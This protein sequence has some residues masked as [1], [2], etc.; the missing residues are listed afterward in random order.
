MTTPIEERGET[1]LGLPYRKGRQWSEIVTID[2]ETAR[3]LFDA[4]PDQRPTRKVNIR[5]LVRAI[6]NG[7]WVVTHQGI[8][9]NVN[10]HVIDGQHRLQAI[11]E[12]GIAV[13]V[14]VTFNLP[15]GAFKA[16]DR[17]AVR[18]FGDDFIN[19]GMTQES[20]ESNTFA[21]A[22]RVLWCYE[23]FGDPTVS[24]IRSIPNTDDLLD[25][26]ERHPMLIETCRWCLT[27][28]SSL[29]FPLGPMAALLTLF[30]EVNN[31]LAINFAAQFITGEGLQRN[32]PALVL[33]E[34][35]L[36]SNARNK[37]GRNNFMFRF[38]RAWNAVCEGRQ[39]SRLYPG[40]MGSGFPAI[41]GLTAKK[42][43]TVKPIKATEEASTPTPRRSRKRKGDGSDQEAFAV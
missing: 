30:R 12:A 13:E 8:A 31:Q 3:K 9:F 38:V 42:K 10:G 25:I 21:A 2:P 14:M 28:R 15:H 35:L 5:K 36:N 43:T 20:K 34:S 24:D 6:K 22:A 26:T 4:M 16:L 23:V 17:G 18:N 19:V 27:G 40:D 39:V 37:L 1:I 29:R 7:E 33:R 11:I 32:D 41:Y